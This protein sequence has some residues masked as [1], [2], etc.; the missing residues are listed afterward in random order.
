MQ[1]DPNGGT[2]HD[3]AAMITRW[4]VGQDTGIVEQYDMILY[5]GRLANQEYGKKVDIPALA[6]RAM[7]E[8]PTAFTREEIQK[9]L[10]MIVE[11]YR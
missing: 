4:A 9:N 7:F 5:L 1:Y 8:F 11:A 10:D 6:H 2:L 3:L